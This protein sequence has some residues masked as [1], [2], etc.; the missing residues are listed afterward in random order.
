MNATTSPLTALP[1]AEATL[2]NAIDNAT[3]AIENVATTSVDAALAR[4]EEAT[5]ACHSRMGL[6]MGQLAS[7]VGSIVD[8]LNGLA[9]DVQEALTPATATTT[10]MVT[11]EPAQVVEPATV[12][13]ISTVEDIMSP[14]A[15][16]EPTADGATKCVVPSDGEPAESGVP[17]GT[18]APIPADLATIAACSPI[19]KAP[20]MPIPTPRS[21][22]RGK[23]R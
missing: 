5:R 8:A 2:V 1:A 7:K 23:R 6:A 22:V 21:K 15:P 3:A 4:L 16:V 17:P 12:G 10:E 18:P 14:T 11:V 9:K 20:P 19:E 13:N